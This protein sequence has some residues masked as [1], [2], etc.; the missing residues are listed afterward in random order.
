[1]MNNIFLAIITCLIGVVVPAVI[2]YLLGIIRTY[3]TQSEALKCLLRSNV[4]SKYYVYKQ[5]GFVPRYE[6]ENVNYMYSQ[7]KK[8][9]GNSYIDVIMADFNELPMKEGLE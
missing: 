4:T 7:Y 1:M 3:K 6:R 8:M 5:M 9:K 2:G